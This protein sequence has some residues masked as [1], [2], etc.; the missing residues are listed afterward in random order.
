MHYSNLYTVDVLFLLLI[1]YCMFFFKFKN[2]MIEKIYTDINTHCIS[3]RI[4]S[5]L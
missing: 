4:I 2:S 5:E 1:G 3:L